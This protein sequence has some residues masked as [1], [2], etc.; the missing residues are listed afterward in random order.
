MLDLVWLLI[1]ALDFDE[2]A[3]NGNGHVIR[4]YPFFRHW[5]PVLIIR[6]IFEMEHKIRFVWV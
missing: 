4:M 6:L 5:L 1:D 2:L 3:D